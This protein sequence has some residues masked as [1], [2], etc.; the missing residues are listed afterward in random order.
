MR[1]NEH[2]DP[3]HALDEFR[4]DRQL[5]Q[6][7][8]CS[9]ADTKRFRRLVKDGGTL[10][11]GVVQRKENRDS[12]PEFYTIYDPPISKDDRMEY[13]LHQHT[14]LLCSIRNCAVFFVCLSIISI[15]AWLYALSR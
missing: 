2:I 9:A 13:I 6:R 4:Y 15:I 5:K 1:D 12:I 8:P 10:P 14:H 11:D 7:I 3:N